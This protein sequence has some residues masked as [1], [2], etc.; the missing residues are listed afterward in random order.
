MRPFHG[1]KGG[2]LSGCPSPRGRFKH[3]PSKAPSPP[4][5][6]SPAQGSPPTQGAPPAQGSLF[7]GSC[8]RSRLRVPPADPSQQAP[9]SPQAAA[10]HT[11]LPLQMGCP[12]T[13]PRLPLQRGCPPPTRLSLQRELSAK[14]TE[15]A[16]RTPPAKP[17]PPPPA[18]TKTGC[19]PPYRVNSLF[20]IH[21]QHHTALPA[22]IA[23]QQ[24]LPS[25]VA[26]PIRRSRVYASKVH[27]STC[28]T[29]GAASASFLW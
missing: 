19:P 3:L 26:G 17:C 10:P 9:T 7:R 1:R 12:F 29:H 11:R 25:S 23:G 15:G 2:D 16:A 20:C 22:V 28:C 4:Q 24:L 14:P 6:A 21:I 18:H 8:R 27:S 13:P 5:G